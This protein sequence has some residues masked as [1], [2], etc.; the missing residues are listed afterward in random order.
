MAE[1][2]PKNW[3]DHVT[4]DHGTEELERQEEALYLSAKA[5]SLFEPDMTQKEW[6]R[7]CEAAE[8]EETERRAK[9]PRQYSELTKKQRRVL[10]KGSESIKSAGVRKVIEKREE[11]IKHLRPQCVDVNDDDF[12][13][14]I[15]KELGITED[16]FK[17]I[18]KSLGNITNEDWQELEKRNEVV[19]E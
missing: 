16:E 8:L 18:D 11:L 19:E 14:E 7:F 10:K 13:D 2:L 15:L 3:R 12:E 5:G 1:Y 17:G 6:N 9:V 4:I